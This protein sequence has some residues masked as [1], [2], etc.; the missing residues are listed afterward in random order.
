MKWSDQKIEEGMKAT[1]RQSQGKHACNWT[2]GRG[3]GGEYEL[4]NVF[5]EITL[6]KNSKFG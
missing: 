2:L 1:V 3:E 5:E 4:T 6:E